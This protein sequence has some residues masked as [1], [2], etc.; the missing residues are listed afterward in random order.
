MGRARTRSRGVVAKRLDS[1][2]SP[3]ARSGAWLKHKHRRRGEFFNTAWVR[4]QPRRPESFFLARR[5]AD[6]S[7][8]RAGSVSIGLAGESREWLRAELQAAELP[9]RRRPQR[10]HRVEASVLATV[11]FHGRSK[12]PVRDAVL[13][14]VR[15]PAADS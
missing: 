8:E 12:G 11:D 9:H 13:R 10:V 6:G 3:G 15:A 1:R 7:L 14:G 2:Y 5:L 4:P